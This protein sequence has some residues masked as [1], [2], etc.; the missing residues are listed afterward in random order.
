[1]RMSRQTVVAVLFNAMMAITGFFFGVYV[2]N[3]QR[4]KLEVVEQLMPHLFGNGVGGRKRDL[5][6]KRYIHF[7]MQAVS[8]PAGTNIRYFFDLRHMRGGLSVCCSA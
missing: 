8:K 3:Y 2:N 5:R 1:M 4:K 7:G 6:R